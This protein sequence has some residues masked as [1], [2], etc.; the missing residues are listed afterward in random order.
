MLLLEFEMFCN[1]GSG[2]ST[3]GV[4]IGMV[5]GRPIGSAGKL[6]PVNDEEPGTTDPEVVII[7]SP[8]HCG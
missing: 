1:C 2:V 3:A 5:A 4:G 6:I 7:F 8:K